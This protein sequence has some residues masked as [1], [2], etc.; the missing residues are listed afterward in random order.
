MDRFLGVGFSSAPEIVN[1]GPNGYSYSY[2]YSRSEEEAKDQKRIAERDQIK[3]QTARGSKGSRVSD[4][5]LSEI[6][7]KRFMEVS[8]NFLADYGDVISGLKADEKIIITN[9]SED[10]EPDFEVMWVNGRDTRRQLMSVEAKRADVEQLKQGKI[11]RNDFMGRLKIVNT[12]T[13]ESLDPDLE[14][15]ASMFS[16]LYRE[17]LSKTYYV[18]GGLNYERLKDF[19]VM[20]YMKVY[21]SIEEDDNRFAI[22]TVSMRGVSQEERDKKVKELYPQFESD[23]KSNLVEYGRTLRSLKDEE[24]LVINVRLTKCAACGIPAMLELSIKSSALK[25]Y[26]SGKATKE[27]TLAKIN[28][29]KTGVQ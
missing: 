26:S 6:A 4:D 8:K 20:Y 28:V 13:A 3:A 11:S 1:V 16:R 19:G 24:Q 10:F 27:A 21:S 5:S 25:D 29:K 17:D 12:E 23:L 9:R 7:H 14:V 15:L 22:P 2:S 18:Q